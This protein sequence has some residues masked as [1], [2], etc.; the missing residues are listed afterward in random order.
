M[1]LRILSAFC[2]CLLA[3]LGA[4][5]CLGASYYFSANGNDTAGNGSLASPWKTIDKFNS[6]NLEPGDEALFR[7][8]DSFA[9]NLYLGAEDTGNNAAGALIN[10]IT[11]GSYGGASSQDR[12]IISAPTGRGMFGY[13]NGGIA[14]KDLEFRGHSS[15]SSNSQGIYFYQDQ[16]AA[17]NKQENIQID[18]V[19]VDGFGRWGVYFQTDRPSGGGYRDVSVTNSEL[20]NNREGGL[21]TVSTDWTGLAYEDVYVGNVVAHDNQGFSGC[22]PHCG[23]GIVLGQVDGAV[24]ENSTA[25]SNG[26]AFG[27]GN[28]AIWTWQS[29]D[30][31]IQHNEAYGNRSPSG[32]DGGGFDLDGGVTNSIVQYNKSYDN[33]GAG[34]LLAQFGYAEPMS[35]NV[36]RYNLSVNDGRDNYGSITIWGETAGDLATSAVFHNNTVVLNNS[37]APN[38]AGVVKFLD[39]YHS[40]IDLINN[41]FVATN[42]ARLIDGSTNSSKA[43]FAKNLYWTDGS[44]RSLE[45]TV[46]ASIAEWAQAESQERI[47][48][49][50]VG[51]EA[52]PQFADL[53]EF[54]PLSGS[55]LL[56]SG[57]EAGSDPWPAWL[58]SIGD[59]DFWGT[60]LPQ[61]SGLEIGAVEAIPGDFNGD[62]L[63]DSTDLGVWQTAYGITNE[64]D[65]DGDGDSDGR[66]YLIWQ[67]QYFFNSAPAVA[68]AAVPEPASLSLF[69]LGLGTML[70]RNMTYHLFAQ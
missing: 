57:I 4:G 18:N 56:N 30:V 1:L 25:F 40:Q 2:V 27:K 48:G 67:R 32:G 70:A 59:S 16:F 47:A 51:I 28:V 37:V 21:S 34:Y 45:G 60:N 3:C 68:Q 13:N 43:T 12:A 39:G 62:G 6:L 42:G 49:Q 69:F 54:R 20:R 38:A 35:Q 44:P 61:G 29:N 58:T 65:A 24:V 15:S 52:N 50:F 46:Y 31:T 41:V 66:D 23:H 33:D 17:S 55:P 8:G 63:V 26:T 5:N 7:A 19:V 14:V 22:A 53:V 11:I 36:F 64:G 9:G 10:P